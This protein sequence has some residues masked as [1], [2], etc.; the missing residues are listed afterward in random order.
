MRRW[1]RDSLLRSTLVAGWTNGFTRVFA[2]HGESSS[3]RSIG[4]WHLKRWG[5]SRTLE[6]I[7]RAKRVGASTVVVTGKLGS[8]ISVESDDVIIQN[9]AE[10]RAEAPQ[11]RARFRWTTT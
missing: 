8:P 10:H 11:A 1:L 4:D 9:G 3:S 5:T 2:P 6:A 7:R